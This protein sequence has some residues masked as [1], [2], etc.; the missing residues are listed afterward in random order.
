[1]LSNI[2]KISAIIIF[3]TLITVI[4]LLQHKNK[5]EIMT[6]KSFSEVDFDEIGA[7]TLI[8]FDVDE[9]L[10]QP[11]D[12]YYMN[13]SS[14]Q[15]QAIKKKLIEDHP[16]IKDWDEYMNILIRQVQRPLLEPMIIEKINAL[17]KSGVVVIAV[18]GMNTGKYGYY[19]RLE[20]WRYEHLGSFG[21]EGSFNDLIID[22]EMNNK[23]PVFYKGILATDTL[24]KG[25]VLFELLDRMNHKPKKIIMFDDSFHFLESV[26]T[27]SKK[28]GIP[29]HGYWY[30]G[31]HE[32]AW[33]QALIEFQIEHLLKHKK[34]LSD[35]KAYELMRQQ[36]ISACA[37]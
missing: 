6:I 11:I 20:R 28:R 7:D 35:E 23:K 24:L 14:P 2:K 9:T 18:T 16:E 1:M 36:P 34:W 13:E 15:A 3:F 12:M 22:F 27:E 29:F 37:Y 10:I 33:D 26:Q 30:K 21:F 25:P 8:V 32:K 5:Y 17:Q 19:D 31:A 4:F